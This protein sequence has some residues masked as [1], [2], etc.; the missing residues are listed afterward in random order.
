MRSSAN[1][2]RSWSSAQKASSTS[3]PYRSTRCTLRWRW[4]SC[5]VAMCKRGCKHARAQAG[6]QPCL[7]A[8]RH[9]NM[10]AALFRYFFRFSSLPPAWTMW[11]SGPSRAL[12]LTSHHLRCGHRGLR[13]REA[14][15]VLSH[16]CTS[17]FCRVCITQYRSPAKRQRSNQAAPALT[18]SHGME[19]MT[20]QRSAPGICA[21]Q[22]PSCLCVP[23]VVAGKGSMVCGPSPT[24]P[25]V[26]GSPAHCWKSLLCHKVCA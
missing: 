3:P 21:L 1:T 16:P 15:P 10:H 22:Q 17:H 5:L 4:V 26:C 14:K 8:C 19:S 11:G 6:I 9:Q 13:I 7:Q 20:Q 25:C 2:R 23:P 24:R 18:P 12:T